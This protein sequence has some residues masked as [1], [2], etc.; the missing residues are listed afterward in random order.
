MSGKLRLYE[1]T[2]ENGR[3]ASPYVWR[4]R[5]ALA[6]KEIPYE[7]V[8][9]G[10]TDIPQ[11]FG[12]RCKTVPVIEHDGTLLVDSW[13]IAEY[14]DRTFHTG[15][16]LFSSAVEL[17]MCKL[18]DA[19]FAPSVARRMLLVY[20]LDV[21]NAAKPEDRAYF[22]Q[23]RE[24]RLQSSLEAVVENRD[25]TLKELREALAPLR[26]HLRRF[27]Y[28]GGARPN[29]ADYIALGAF[30]WVGSVSTLPIL[31]RDDE[32]LRDWLERGLDLY[33]GIGRDARLKPLVE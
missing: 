21:H 31:A 27:P 9:L 8:M 20:V 14:L 12:G 16:P 24:A 10:F 25:A 23:S 7:S 15:V 5:Y 11:A 3:S 30:L 2:L 22:R 28:L 32:V 29:Y 13:D 18:M 17:A 6:Q 26:T 33:G 1:L 4:I 19:W